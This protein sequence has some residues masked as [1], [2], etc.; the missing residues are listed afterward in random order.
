[1]RKHSARTDNISPSG[2]SESLLRFGCHDKISIFSFQLLTDVEQ[3]ERV[4]C[5]ETFCG[6]HQVLMRLSNPETRQ[7]LQEAPASS[8]NKASPWWPWLQPKLSCPMAMLLTGDRVQPSITACDAKQ[9]CQHSEYI[10]SF[11]MSSTFATLCRLGDICIYRNIKP[12]HFCRESATKWWNKHR[13]V[14][15]RQDMLCWLVGLLGQC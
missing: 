1:M 14:K 7:R 6:M 4:G 5:R 10:C 15:A 11:S 3:D 9:G 13:N 8:Q 12:C 2:C